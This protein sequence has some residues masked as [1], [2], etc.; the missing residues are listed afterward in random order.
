MTR[1]ADNNVDP[2]MLKIKTDQ[3]TPNR[4]S[5]ETSSSSSEPEMSGDKARQLKNSRKKREYGHELDMLDM[6]N[7][8]KKKY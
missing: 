3:G 7:K 6:Q 5:N 2:E 8:K 4:S 1:P